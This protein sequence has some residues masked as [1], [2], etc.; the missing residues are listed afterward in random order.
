MERGSDFQ[1]YRLKEA[2]LLRTGSGQGHSHSDALDLNLFALGARMAADT[3]TRSEGQLWS[4]PASSFSMVHNMVEVDGKNHPFY[5]QEGWPPGNFT[6]AEAWVETFKPLGEVQF[7]AGS[8]AASMH[9]DVTYYHREA[10]LIGVAQGRESTAAYPEKITRQTKLPSGIELPRSY[11]FDVFRVAGGRWHTWCFH[12]AV[13][14]DFQV[15][16]ELRPLPEDASKDDETDKLSRAY[17]RKLVNTRVG[18]TTDTVEATWRLSRTGA[19]YQTPLGE[20]ETEP[21][22]QNM[23]GVNYD[24]AAPRRFT[25]V[26]LLGH[27][28]APLLIGSAYSQAYK[29]LFPFL[30]V[31]LRGDEKGRESVF[32]AIIEAYQG[33]PTVTSKKLLPIEN[34]ETDAR[35]AVAVE[36]GTVNGHTDICFAGGR[37]EKVRTVAGKDKMSGEFAYLSRDANGLRVAT[38]IGGQVLQSDGISIQSETGKRS[39]QIIAADY[40]KRQITLDVALPEVLVGQE[41]RIF[42]ADHHTSYTIEKIENRDGHAVVTFTRTSLMAR[43]PIDKIEGDKVTLTIMPFEGPA[44][45]SAG[46]TATDEAHHKLWKTKTGWNEMFHFAGAP[47]ALA[48]FTDADG[49]G[50]ATVEMYDY[51]V[52]DTLE[53]PTHVSLMRTD[54][55]YEV[56]SDVAAQITMGATTHKVLPAALPVI[57]K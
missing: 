43:S 15:N 13:S 2:M 3:A 41:A 9:P 53:L 31:Q 48:D 54:K 11:I 47:V 21:G 42:N 56:R 32:P 17:L 23:L 46:W 40:S 39:A 26:S 4:Q 29:Y 37:P 18:T 7:V 20:V 35:Q 12:G 33:E 36:V 45:R 1:D 22:E 16:S 30:Y 27:G 44:N 57:I 34:N 38:L 50:R 8:A 10:A 49:D 5:A 19:K 14:D 52:G 6:N 24:P 51:G 25:R 28:G 55:G